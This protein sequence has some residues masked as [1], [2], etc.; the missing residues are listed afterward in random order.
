MLVI[1]MYLVYK[2]VEKKIKHE[3]TG[4]HKGKKKLFQTNIN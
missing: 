4:C 1:K 3:K 2:V